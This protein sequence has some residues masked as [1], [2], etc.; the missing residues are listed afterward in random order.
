MTRLA[1][2]DK[3]GCILWAGDEVGDEGKE[4]FVAAVVSDY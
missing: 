1:T 3:A 4:V 2:K